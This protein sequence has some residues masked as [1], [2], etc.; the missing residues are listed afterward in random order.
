MVTEKNM[1]WYQLS[2]ETISRRNGIEEFKKKKIDK[3]QATYFILHAHTKK[4]LEFLNPKCQSVILDTVRLIF[5]AET[6]KKR[7][8]IILMNMMIKMMEESK[9]KKKMIK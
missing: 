7:K 2:S 6:M 4:K 9:Q 5:A 3:K 8:K 1:G